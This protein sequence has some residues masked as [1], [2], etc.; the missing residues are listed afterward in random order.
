MVLGLNA[1]VDFRG[2]EVVIAHR[3]ENLP[4]FR[5]LR[6]GLVG[7]RVDAQAGIER[8]VDL[9]V[10]AQ[11]E[12][13]LHACR[14]NFFQLAAVAPEMDLQVAANVLA[15]GF[16]K[17]FV[18]PWRR[19]VAQVA[20]RQQEGLAIVVL[21]PGTFGQPCQE[22]SLRD[23]SSSSQAMMSTNGRPG[24]IGGNWFG[25]PTRI[26]PVSLF[27]SRARNRTPRNPSGSSRL[28]R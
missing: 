15:G 16:G 1:A 13:Q 4:T 20:V 22:A 26:K 9:P 7:V 8:P 28:R 10:V 18:V 11:I 21:V 23:S 2:A 19:I 27:K 12:Q 14:E 6:I 17:Q 3:A 25:S 24:P 5:L